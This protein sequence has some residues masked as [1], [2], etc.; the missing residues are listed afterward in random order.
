MHLAQRLHLSVV[1]RVGEERVGRMVR[2]E[3]LLEEEQVIHV[4]EDSLEVRGEQV[5]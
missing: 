5:L 3:S 1:E 4:V 2:G